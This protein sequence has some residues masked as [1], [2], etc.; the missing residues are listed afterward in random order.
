MGSFTFSAFHILPTI[1]H[2]FS[3]FDSTFYFPH[4]AI[5]HF[6]HLISRGCAR[7]VAISVSIRSIMCGWGL[8][9]GLGLV[10]VLHYIWQFTVYEH[11]VYG[12]FYM[13]VNCG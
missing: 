11:W 7:E 8:G 5:P 13:A 9:L 2:S 10:L 4:S 3:V 6:T 1:L 12:K